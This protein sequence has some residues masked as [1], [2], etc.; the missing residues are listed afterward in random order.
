M[1]R[2]VH[3]LCGRIAMIFFLV[4]SSG[5]LGHQFHLRRRCDMFL[6][7]WSTSL[8]GYCLPIRLIVSLETQDRVTPT[9]DPSERASCLH[10][11]SLCPNRTLIWTA[12][13]DHHAL[14]HSVDLKM[15]WSRGQFTSR[16]SFTLEFPRNS[17]RVVYL[18]HDAI[19]SLSFSMTIWGYS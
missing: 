8:A 5:L 10:A 3:R 16:K 2:I 1:H 6:R 9:M 7:H 4:Q 17:D 15:P 18:L 14:L 11:T 13:A 12:F 19:L